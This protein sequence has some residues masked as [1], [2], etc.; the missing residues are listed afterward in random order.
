MAVEKKKSKKK[1]FTILVGGAGMYNIT[2]GLNRIGL[3]FSLATEPE[4]FK[5]LALAGNYDAIILADNLFLAECVGQKD[6][7]KNRFLALLSNLEKMEKAKSKKIWLIVT[8]KKQDAWK[9]FARFEM[10]H[11][12]VS[13][14]SMLVFASS[15]KNWLEVNL[16][17]KPKKAKA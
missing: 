17:T 14:K 13:A 2:A 6:Q 7:A 9:I 12:I 3:E 8:G 16:K 11:E 15:L 5:S 10:V 1:V 4:K